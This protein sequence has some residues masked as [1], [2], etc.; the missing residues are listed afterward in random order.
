MAL[1][2]S[3][4]FNSV[5]SEVK[6]LQLMEIISLHNYIN[7]LVIRDDSQNLEK[8]DKRSSKARFNTSAT[9]PR[10]REKNRES[11]RRLEVLYT[12]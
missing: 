4:F 2:L 6:L 3:L 5:V 11:I 9:L 7:F 12:M 10:L 1:I 8:L